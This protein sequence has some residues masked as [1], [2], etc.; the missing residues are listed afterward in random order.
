MYLLRSLLPQVST[1]KCV[2]GFV[3]LCLK[4]LYMYIVCIDKNN[5]S[6]VILLFGGLFLGS[7][8]KISANFFQI[9]SYG[10][11]ESFG[12]FYTLSKL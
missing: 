7:F 1:I 2:K 9:K 6:T 3:S 10:R 8:I 11:T 4:L 12:H 5:F